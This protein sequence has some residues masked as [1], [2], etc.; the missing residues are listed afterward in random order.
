[1]SNHNRHHIPLVVF[2]AVLI[3]IVLVAFANKKSDPGIPV[4]DDKSDVSRLVHAIDNFDPWQETY[5]Q[6]LAVWIS[7]AGAV[8]SW[9]AVV[10]VKQTFEVN[11]GATNAAVA[12]VEASL[13]ANQLAREQVELQSRAWI[14]FDTFALRLYGAPGELEAAHLEFIFQNTGVTPA[15]E[16]T[17]FSSS[18]ADLAFSN[19]GD[20]PMEEFTPI[21]PMPPSGRHHSAFDFPVD[22][23]FSS[24]DNPITIHITF[25]YRTIFGA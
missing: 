3:A 23:I 22:V 7:A 8:I 16:V 20:T 24:R 25:R 10:L 14:S 15:N 1:M 12:G 21:G 17:A 18:S 6:W 5:A 9:R 4:D 19:P 13:Q 11:R 2:I